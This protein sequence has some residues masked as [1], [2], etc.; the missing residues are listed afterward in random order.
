[1]FSSRLFSIVRLASLTT[2]RHDMFIF[3]LFNL[4]LLQIVSFD[5]VS[6]NKLFDCLVRST[7]RSTNTLLWIIYHWFSFVQ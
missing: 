4:P 2:T 7:T 5:K 6:N 1:V 3:A